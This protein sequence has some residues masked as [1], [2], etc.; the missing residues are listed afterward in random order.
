MHITA[1]AYFQAIT[2]PMHYLEHTKNHTVTHKLGKEI[3]SP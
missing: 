2:R 1:L 3:S